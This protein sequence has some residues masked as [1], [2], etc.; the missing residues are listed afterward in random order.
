MSRNGQ[1]V[2]FMLHQ[3]DRYIIHF[4]VSPTLFMIAAI[5]NNVVEISYLLDLYVLLLLAPRV[6]ALCHIYFSSLGFYLVANSALREQESMT[7]Q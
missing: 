5:A 7:L 1:D 6:E 2:S 4:T 3:K